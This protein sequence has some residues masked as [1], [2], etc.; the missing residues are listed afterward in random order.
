MNAQKILYHF[1]VKIDKKTEACNTTSV[2]SIIN[3]KLIEN[4]FFT[5]LFL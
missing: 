2:N 5:G 3:E 4:T 1:H